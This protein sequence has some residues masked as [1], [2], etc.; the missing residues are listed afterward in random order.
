MNKINYAIL[1]L[2]A[3]IFLSACGSARSVSDLPY[4]KRKKFEYYYFEG[5][6]QKVLENEQLALQYFEEALRVHPKSH[7]SMNQLAV[8]Y[9]KQAKYPESLEWAKKSVDLNPEYN[10]WYYGQLAQCYSQLGQYKDAAKT[11]ELMIQNEPENGKL[12]VDACNQYLN[13]GD[14]ARALHVLDDM[15]A[16]IGVTELSATRKEYIYLKTGRSEL[17]IK[18]LRKLVNAYPD[19]AVYR[20]YLA[21]TLMNTGNES[22]AIEELLEMEKIDP[23]FGRTQLLLYQ[24]YGK[25]GDELRSYVHLKKAFALTDIDINEKLKTFTPYFMRFTMSP[26]ARLQTM[27]LSD[28]LMATYPDKDIPYI[29]KGDIYTKLDSLSKAREYFKIAVEKDGS[30]YRTWDKLISIDAKLQRSDLQLEDADAAILR[31]PNMPGFYLAKA[32]ALY[33]L[34]RYSEVIA[35][36]KDGLDITT[37]NAD[38]VEFYS[39]LASSYNDLKDFKNSDK[40]FDL[41]L[42]LDKNSTLIRNN[43]AYALAM[44]GEKLELAD[45]LSKF[46]LFF[47]PDNP[48]YMDT[49]AWVLF[50]KGEHQQ[51]IILLKK[52]ASIDPQGFEYYEHLA[53]IYHHLGDELNAQKY[54]EKA[55]E[56]GS[57]LNTFDEI[58]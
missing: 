45:S 40:Y 18:E 22:E 47:E 37:E 19:K 39:V 23:S 53:K 31:Y 6:K 38:L 57:E 13:A 9:F 48:Y 14:A 41:S 55:R 29:V 7:A 52:A 3:V 33:D 27:E 15:E 8:L 43:Y 28:I 24:L 16:A 35:A 30:D 10:H 2:I 20:G 1:S 26:K 51:A 49:R 32:Y 46:C 34:G 21:E 58:I 12:Y 44:R 50:K 56:L 5:A 54:L 36:A 17:A 42:K 11:F 4:K 25:R